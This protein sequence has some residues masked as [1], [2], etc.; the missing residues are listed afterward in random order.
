MRHLSDNRLM[1][2]RDREEH[3]KG[4][5]NVSLLWEKELLS[6]LGTE[7]WPTTACFVEA[8]ENSTSLLASLWSKNKRLASV[9]WDVSPGASFGGIGGKGAS[10]FRDMSRVCVTMAFF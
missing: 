10:F 3:L 9:A 8:N 2:P 4:E 5:V 7:P 6:S 1:A